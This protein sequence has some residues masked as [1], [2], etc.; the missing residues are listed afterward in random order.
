MILPKVSHLHWAP[1]I[2][3]MCTR[4]SIFIATMCRW[5]VLFIAGECS[6]WAVMAGL[7]LQDCRLRL[8]AA[9]KCSY[10]SKP[11]TSPATAVHPVLYIKFVSSS[12]VPLPGIYGLLS[13][14][15]GIKFMASLSAFV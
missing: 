13:L 10:T 8:P 4:I 14:I 3:L 6:K 9:C 5:D 11:Q 1:I 2:Y 7:Y 15:L 12:L